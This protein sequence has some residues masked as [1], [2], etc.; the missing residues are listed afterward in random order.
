MA[1]APLYRN[2]VG[3]SLLFAVPE[4]GVRLKIKEKQ[5]EGKC[6]ECGIGIETEASGGPPVRDK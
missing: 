2:H 1:I 3:R 5:E 4:K 6:L